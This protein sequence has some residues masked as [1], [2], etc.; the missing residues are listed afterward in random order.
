M[1][2]FLI[3][4]PFL[5][6]FLTSNVDLFAEENLKKEKKWWLTSHYTSEYLLYTT[7]AMVLFFFEVFAFH[8]P[9][10]GSPSFFL[11]FLVSTTYYLLAF[12]SDYE[13]LIVSP[14]RPDPMKSTATP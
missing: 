12:H 14:P 8:F 4:G 1:C 10:F 11:F 6:L 7:M 3:V 13:V 2:K 5:L 9:L